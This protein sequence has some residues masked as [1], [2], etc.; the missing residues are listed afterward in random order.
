MGPIHLI[1]QMSYKY[2]WLDYTEKVISEL[3]AWID[4][5][6]D[7]WERQKNK[8]AKIAANW[9]LSELFKHLK[10]GGT[11]YIG[12]SENPH[13]LINYTKRV[14]QNI[15]IKIKDIQMVTLG[16]RDGAIE[17][18]NPGRLLL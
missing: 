9:L 13:D 5:T 10:V 11:L 1:A 18:I 3:R 2:A 8:L 15:F 4:A 12:H 6:D 17:K 7:S 16:H 14:G